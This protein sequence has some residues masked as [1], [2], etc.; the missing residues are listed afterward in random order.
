LQDTRF[1][2]I[3]KGRGF[4]RRAPV[5]S[6]FPLVLWVC[7]AQQGKPPLDRPVE[8][9][10]HHCLPGMGS[11]HF[12]TNVHRLGIGHLSRCCCVPRGVVRLLRLCVRKG[13]TV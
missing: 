3:E 13:I 9:G 5:P 1:V 4:F 7:V 12:R 10:G 6:A 2:Q 11:Q 8:R